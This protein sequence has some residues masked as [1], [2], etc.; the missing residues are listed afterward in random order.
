MAM[1]DYGVIAKKNGEFVNDGKN[2]Y[3][4][5]KGIT[6]LYRKGIGYSLRD[7][8]I[9]IGDN[10][11]VIS[12]YKTLVRMSRGNEN[13]FI[14][15]LYDFE[16]KKVARFEKYG[17]NF[18]QK[19]IGDTNSNYLRFI[20]KDDVYEIIYG[21]GVDFNLKYY[22]GLDKKGKRFVKKFLGCN[23]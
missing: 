5:T 7:Y 15:F 8:F 13:C 12:F 17:I 1:I 23:K 2:I 14:D 9:N 19:V 20:Y 16:H 3:F 21:Y 22:W 4:N 10:E 6:K 18:C 11:F